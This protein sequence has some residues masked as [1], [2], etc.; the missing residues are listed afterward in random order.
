[1]DD[2]QTRDGDELLDGD[3]LDAI[4][5]DA[6]LAEEWD[7]VE[8][9]SPTDAGDYDFTIDADKESFAKDVTR[10]RSGC[11][12]HEAY[13]APIDAEKVHAAAETLD[14]VMSR[15]KSE[16]VAR[17][18]HGARRQSAFWEVIGALRELVRGF[19]L[20]FTE[21]VI[22][23]GWKFDR[24]GALILGH[25]MSDVAA[26]D[27]K[28]LK[29]THVI[30]TVAHGRITV[31]VARVWNE[32]K[33]ALGDDVWER[34][35]IWNVTPYKAHAHADSV[36]G[37]KG[38]P[39]V[40]SEMMAMSEFLMIEQSVRLAVLLLGCHTIVTFGERAADFIERSKR[41]AP[42]ALA[43]TLNT[44]TSHICYLRAR[45]VKREKGHETR[46]FVRKEHYAAFGKAVDD[47]LAAP[48]FSAQVGGT[49]AV[50]AE[51]RGTTAAK[52][53]MERTMQKMDVKEIGGEF[54]AYTR[55]EAKERQKKR[56]KKRA[57]EYAHESC[58]NCFL[59]GPQTKIKRLTYIAAKSR[60]SSRIPQDRRTAGNF[61]AWH[62]SKFKKKS[63]L[64]TRVPYKRSGAKN[65][66]AW[67][68]SKFNDTKKS[69][70]D[71]RVPY[72]RSG[73]KNFLAWSP[74]TFSNKKKSRLDTRVPYKRSGAK[75]FL[76]WSPKTFNNKKKS[77]LDTRV[78]RVKR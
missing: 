72:K 59:G 62:W 41:V 74:I 12:P 28:N 35:T 21:P 23:K 11:L 75:N 76:A 78:P 48:A 71:T 2:A 6:G 51:T 14:D 16:M 47:I 57:R 42:L 77:R 44:A 69:R 19:G 30:N 54:H 3:L 8:D 52:A 17:T 22:G 10:G 65:F 5:L 15:V 13:Y 43:T 32:W 29:K 68:H 9:D 61:L 63:R 53:F 64:D 49:T 60:F 27:S 33:R 4:A 37:H 58:T 7:E 31:V 55:E 34:V 36:S 20:E 40:S 70:L 18:L 67:S 50:G 38:K 1:M 26:H 56:Q 46:V 45:G 73:A 25:F 24:K 66:L 39:L